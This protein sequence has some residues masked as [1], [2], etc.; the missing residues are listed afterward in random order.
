VNVCII[1]RRGQGKSTLSRYLAMKKRTVIIFDPNANFDEG[2]VALNITEFQE[3][4]YSQ[5]PAQ[6]QCVCVFR[7]RTGKGLTEDFALM[8]EMLWQMEDFCLIVD[9]ASSVQGSHALHEKLELVIRQAPRTG[10][11]AWWL[12]Q[13]THRITDFHNLSR[14]L[15]SD[16]FIFQTTNVRDLDMIEEQFGPAVR[17]TVQHLGE[18]QCV[19]CWGEKNGEQKSEIWAD[20]QMWFVP[21]RSSVNNAGNSTYYD[22]GSDT[23]ERSPAGAN[24]SCN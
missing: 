6:G 14:S 2:Y 17:E 10:P 18:Y 9:E 1:G 8:I 22:P 19:H 24:V 4:L 12:I 21:L 7:P 5:K 11:G 3:W 20:P 15:S 13:S 16:V 23:A